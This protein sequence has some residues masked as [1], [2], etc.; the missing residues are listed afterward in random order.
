V[1][2]KQLASH[3]TSDR[4]GRTLLRLVLALLTLATG[5]AA[6]PAPSLPALPLVPPSWLP[7][8]P[9][10]H[11]ALSAVLGGVAAAGPRSGWDGVRQEVFVGYLAALA[12]HGPV[13]TPELFPS[14]AHILA[15][16]VNAHA[17]WTIALGEARTLRKLGV[18]ALREVPF[19]LDGRMST[20]ATLAEEVARY[21]PREPRL[22][23]FLNPGWQGG[24]PLPASALEGHSLDWQLAS[25]AELCGRT[26]DFWN[27]DR[28]RRVV[29]VSAF[30]VFMWGLPA[31]Q[32][33][34]MRKL[35]ELVPPPGQ[36][37][38]AIL[39]TCGPSLQRC[40]MAS[41]A[42]D[43]SRLFEAGPRR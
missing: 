9:A 29:S 14:E 1:G 12:H 25:H 22:A 4:G 34:R 2:R 26:P 38:Q 10:T 8:V 42:C 39:A 23:L 7:A 3:G 16:L 24:P 32:P 37:R 33:A 18:G 19:P 20:L 31:E 17:A 43:R 11:D 41:I 28:E 6:P 21:A 27:L 35:L 40:T 15:Y 5:C 13:S 30:T 36:L